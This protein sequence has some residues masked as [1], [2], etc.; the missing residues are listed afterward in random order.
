MGIPYKYTKPYDTLNFTPS[1]GMK[2]AQPWIVFSDRDSNRTY[3]TPNS[4]ATVK[5]A[6]FLEPFYVVEEDINFVYI[7]KDSNPKRRVSKNAVDYGWIKKENLLLWRRGL[8]NKENVLRKAMILN[9]EDSVKQYRGKK[10]T[11]LV[12]FCNDPELTNE[13]QRDA[14]VFSLYYIYKIYPGITNPTAALI[15]KRSHLSPS[16]IQE[17]IIG[18]IDYSKLTSW[19]FRVVLYPDLSATP[20]LERRELNKPSM[21]FCNEREASNYMNGLEIDNSCIVWNEIQSQENH[22]E[23]RFRF[24]LLGIDV[25]E[26][27]VTRE[28]ATVGVIKK[29][30]AEFIPIVDHTDDRVSQVLDQI[31][32]QRK[33][34]NLIFVIHGDQGMYD[35]FQRI[36]EAV[37]LFAQYIQIHPEKIQ[38]EIGCVIYRDLA[39]GKNM[40]EIIPLTEDLM[41]V[42]KR[43]KSM[44]DLPSKDRD[45]SDALFFGIQKAVNIFGLSPGQSNFLFVIGNTGNHKRDDESQADIKVIIDKLFE[46]GF[47]F[48]AFQLKHLGTD[49]Y[50]DFYYQTEEILSTLATQYLDV[51][52]SIAIKMS[53]DIP[54]PSYI[55]PE[56]IDKN[57]YLKT[58][59]HMNGGIYALV[60]GSSVPGK[61][62]TTLLTQR[63]KDLYDSVVYQNGWIEWMQQTLL[64]APLDSSE[65]VSFRKF[66]IPLNLMG[67]HMEVMQ[68]EVYYNYLTGYVAILADDCTHPLWQYQLFCTMDEVYELKSALQKLVDSR[69]ENLAR[70]VF[71]EYWMDLMISKQP[72]LSRTE[73]KRKTLKEVEIF[74]FGFYR[75][76]RYADFMLEEIA[77][78]GKIPDSELISWIEHIKSSV[79]ELDKIFNL[80]PT[81]SDY[82]FVSNDERY[83][84][85][86]CRFLP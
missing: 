3:T 60:P 68:S 7:Y 15:G 30:A 12:A 8:F 14:D 25:D 37:R 81:H 83:F 40:T 78:P 62:L 84:W 79:R 28:I 5:L 77:D 45:E 13:N 38:L 22:E 6:S 24:P 36:S 29:V 35:Y 66:L 85:I 53:H 42:S 54:Q 27:D 72:R 21:I 50:S 33:H 65:T 74:L 23:T 46:D 73:I 80:Y 39:Y 59:S 31:S 55:V 9:T 75:D 82:S 16:S 56:K 51:S 1:E 32:E 44:R 69:V 20:M 43:I 17:D 2:T 67:K 18:W 63:L 64:S 11:G 26:Y 41:E 70:D 52:K 47:G 4:T 58:K 10:E 19:N 49:P 57:I 71:I 34:L 48:Y 76:S 61:T 86:P